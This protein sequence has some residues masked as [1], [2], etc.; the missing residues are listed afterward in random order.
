MKA[1]RFACGLGLL[2]TL[3]CGGNESRCE[4]MCDWLERCIDEDYDCSE[5]SI[6]ECAEDL[7][8][9]S[10][11]CLDATDELLDCL[12][13]NESCEDSLASCTSEAAAAGEKCKF[14]DENSD[15]GGSSGG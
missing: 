7:D 3:G 11:A 2:L 14:D 10:D 5:S 12:N 1:L 15:S 9:E 4:E 13:E 8:E 6:E